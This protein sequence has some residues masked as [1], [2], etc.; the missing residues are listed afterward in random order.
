MKKSTIPEFSNQDKKELN[1]FREKIDEIDDQILE[2]LNRRVEIAKEI[3]KFKRKRGIEAYQ[4]DREREV[5]DRLCKKNKGLF[6]N[7]TLKVLYREIMSASR[8]WEEPLKIA[9]LGPEA[10]F[11]HQ[12]ALEKFGASCEFIPKKSISEIF[13]EVESGRANYGVVPIENSSEGVIT[14]TLDMFIDSELK[15]CSEIILKISQNLLSNNHL[16]DI[17]RVYYHVQ[18]FAQSRSWLENN[19]PNVEYIEVSSTAEAARRAAQENCAAIASE[20]AANIYNLNI[21]IKGIE[22]GKEN[23][24][25]FLVIGRE[26]SAPTGNDKTSILFSIKDR[27]GALHD[28][29]I[30]FA[31]HGINLTKIE[32]RPSRKQVWEYIFFLDLQGHVKDENVKEALSELENLCLFLKLLGSYPAGE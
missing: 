18:S 13:D 20:L 23:Y 24:T 31:K 15:I 8:A 29:L 22:T 28:M 19:L 9:Y 12:A 16:E 6:P 26:V 5:Y 21:V 11:T 10:T 30:P 17:K 3:G 27:V 14:H 2:L 4:P 7:K 1:K 25:R 32:S